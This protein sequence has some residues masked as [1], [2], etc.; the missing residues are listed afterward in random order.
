MLGELVG[1]RLW[2]G[3]FLGLSGAVIV[4]KPTR[5]FRWA[6]LL[7]LATAFCC[8][9][10]Q[11]S[12]HFLSQSDP[13]ITTLFYTTANGA[14]LSLFAVPFVWLQPTAHNWILLV[15]TGLYGGLGR[16]AL[17]CSI[18]LAE[19]ATVVLF[20]YTAVIWARGYGFI[21][22]GN[23]P[24]KWVILGSVV[25]VASGLY[26]FFVKKSI[27]ASN[28]RHFRF[29]SQLKLYLVWDHTGPA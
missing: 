28:T 24:D 21:V 7:P 18:N 25:I 29:Q 19:A 22:F 26:V 12:T 15:F 10:Y 2:L 6:T 4:I 20:T 3:V 14:L 5:T 13:V 16:L 11:L 1:R 27:N 23:F 17:I 8:T 9:I